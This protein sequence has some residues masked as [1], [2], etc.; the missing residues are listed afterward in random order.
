M[1]YVG[2]CSLR[3]YLKNFENRRLPEREAKIIFREVVSGIEY[4][5]T[6]NV[7]H[8]DIKLENILLTDE[9]KTVKLVDFGFA[10]KVS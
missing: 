1:E 5:H 9:G 3:Q 7:C 10:I 6:Q 2:Q 4:C 8:R